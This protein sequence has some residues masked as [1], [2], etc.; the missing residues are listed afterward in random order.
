M[1]KVVAVYFKQKG[2]FSTPEELHQF[3]KN[4]GFGLNTHIINRIEQVFAPHWDGTYNGRP[5]QLAPPNIGPNR[6]YVYPAL[7][8]TME[9]HEAILQ[10]QIAEEKER[11]EAE[12]KIRDEEEAKRRLQVLRELSEP[13][14]GW[15]HVSITFNRYKYH[16]TQGMLP[17]ESTFSG[18]TIAEN[19]MG[20]YHKAVA[21]VEKEYQVIDVPNA[22]DTGA[23][24]A[25][26]LGVKTDN[27]YSVELWEKWRKEGVI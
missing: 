5:F 25:S 1:K 23:F 12:K 20:A 13:K 24:H 18:T 15:Y 4:L 2:M 21:A 6:I 26:F 27:G 11:Q 9:Q 8:D 19:G 22:H 3:I 10:K 16:I 14:K 17:Q 7:A